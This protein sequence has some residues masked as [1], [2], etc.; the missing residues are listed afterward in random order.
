MAQKGVHATG[1]RKTASARVVLT[2]SGGEE[3]TFVVNGRAFKSFFPSDVTQMVIM[4]PFAAT[5]RLGAYNVRATVR[6][7]GVSGQAGALLLGLAR[8]LQTAEPDLRGALKERGFLTRDSRAVERK[9]PGRH[10]ARRRPQF[11][12]R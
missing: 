8:A 12:K 6:G 7:G 5:E 10:K 2:P 11:S 9:K 4:Q 1:R 3:T